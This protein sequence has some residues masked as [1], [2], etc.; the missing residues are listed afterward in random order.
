MDG[1]GLQKLAEE[2]MKSKSIN[3][4]TS[5]S[6]IAVEDSSALDGSFT[7]VLL[8]D[9]GRRVPFHEAILCTQV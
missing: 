8:T 1:R 7:G 3:V 4:F 6:I 5:A 2:F 9:D